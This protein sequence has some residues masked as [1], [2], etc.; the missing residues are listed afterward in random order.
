M[1]T[2]ITPTISIEFNTAEQETADWIASA[3]RE[4]LACFQKIGRMKS[5]RSE[6]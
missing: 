3:A 6:K 5:S 4:A 2:Q 1:K